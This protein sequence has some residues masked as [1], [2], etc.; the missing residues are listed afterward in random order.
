MNRQKLAAGLTLVAAYLGVAITG[1][2]IFDQLGA[3][4]R[5]PVDAA[6]IEALEERVKTEAEVAVELEAERE[7]QTQ[8]SLVRETR[9][10]RLGFGLLVAMVAF[11]SGANWQQTHQGVPPLTKGGSRG[12]FHA[13]A[14][15][16]D[17]S[18][19]KKSP[20]APLFQRG[21][22]EKSEDL[23]LAV[24]DDI[25]GR[26]GI[27]REAA[28]PILQ[29]LQTHFR[30][31][32]EPALRR[33]AELTEVTPSQIAGIASFYA[34]FRSTPTGRH[35]VR[36]CH[37][38]ACHVAGIDPIMDELRRRLGI[39]TGDDTDPGRR[40]TLDPVACLG[41][42]SL[43]PVMMV[44]DDVAGRLTPASACEALVVQEAE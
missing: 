12:D 27:D 23:D 41:C 31:L 21:E 30:Y 19:G 15:T 44:D 36:V 14:P 18:A 28:I 38:T 17:S 6:V 9:Q 7:R 16:N 39:P 29:A 13:T 20:L 35:L 25:V 43:A 4:R 34:M 42:C 33:V 3:Q 37:G 32:P 10:R 8:R 11:L 1:F 26:F 24:V 5:A 2:L 22:P 40:F